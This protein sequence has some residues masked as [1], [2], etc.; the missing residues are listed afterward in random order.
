MK[1]SIA[2]FQEKANKTLF[3]AGVIV[4]EELRRSRIT[5]AT[6]IG[7]PYGVPREAGGNWRRERGRRLSRE[8]LTGPKPNLNV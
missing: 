7:R 5:W 3:V 6:D 8:R 1:V 4:P 2:S